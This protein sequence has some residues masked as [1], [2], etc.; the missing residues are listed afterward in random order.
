VGFELPGLIADAGYP[1][2]WVDA[3][4]GTVVSQLRLLDAPELSGV[5]ALPEGSLALGTPRRLILLGPGP[6]D[7]RTIGLEHDGLVGSAREG[8]VVARR[9]QLVIVDPRSGSTATEL[10]RVRG[11][12]ELG[13]DLDLQPS[14]RWAVGRAHGAVLAVDLA[15]GRVLTLS[16]AALGAPRAVVPTRYGLVAAGRSVLSLDLGLGPPEALLE[17]RLCLRGTC[18]SG[19]GALVDPVSGRHYSGGFKAGEPSGQGVLRYEDGTI[20]SGPFVKGRPHGEGRILTPEGDERRVHAEGG[21]LTP[22]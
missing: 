4:T 19:E 6:S 12:F 16:H 1:V 17:R 14:G 21:A 9:G 7:A 15:G 20:Y 3:E 13:R 18:R 2:V 11:P 10:R 5:A 22:L 8:L